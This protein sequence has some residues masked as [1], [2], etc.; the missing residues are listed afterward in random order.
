M[1]TILARK[2]YVRTVIYPFSPFRLIKTKP[3]QPNNKTIPRLGGACL[4]SQHLGDY[5]GG[6][7]VQSQPLL[8]NEILSKIKIKQNN[9]LLIT[10]STC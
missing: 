9:T 3:N 4:Q 1:Q 5:G 8:Y 2:M 6:S 7:Q 10:H